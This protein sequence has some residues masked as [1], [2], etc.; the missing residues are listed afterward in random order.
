MIPW[1][2]LALTAIAMLAF[3]GNS[4]LCRLALRNTAI[5][6]VTFTSIRIVAGAIMLAMIVAIRDRK[7]AGL[8]SWSCAVPLF[9]YAICFSL[10]YVSLPAGI[11]ALLLFGAVQVTMIGYGFFTGDRFRWQQWIGILIAIAGLVSLVAPSWLSFSNSTLVV[12]PMGADQVLSQDA[13]AQID[14][15]EPTDELLDKMTFAIGSSLMLIAGVSWG[16]YSLMAKGVG[17]PT[18]VTARNFLR[19]VPLVIFCSIV[20]GGRA[21]LDLNGVIYAITSGAITSGIGYTIW[22]MAVRS[23]EPTIAATVQLSVP[24][25]AG[26]AGYLFLGEQIN[27]RQ[28]VASCAVMG[29]VA[30]VI[31]NKKQPS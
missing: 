21:S 4:L 19:A 14:L 28:F 8:G 11:G 16:I 9:A 24:V 10:A 27:L 3:A 18:V 25:L 12:N 6:P 22:Y 1:K 15:A 2:I 7:Y 30:I 26:I 5:D 31:I 20:L 29:G 23:L 17:D 13:Q